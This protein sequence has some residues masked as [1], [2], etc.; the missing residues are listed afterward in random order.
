MQF[1]V[2]APHISAEV[3]TEFAACSWAC[4]KFYG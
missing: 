1:R 4:R 2:Q 3:A